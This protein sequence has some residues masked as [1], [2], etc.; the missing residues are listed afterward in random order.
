[1]F[2]FEPK[3]IHLNVVWPSRTILDGLCW[4][5]KKIFF[6]NVLQLRYV[7]TIPFFK[8]TVLMNLFILLIFRR[9]TMKMTTFAM[10]SEKHNNVCCGRWLEYIEN[11]HLYPS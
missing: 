11:V 6:H 8:Y 4:Y 3:H 2:N 7:S 9:H 10:K 1:M 5:N